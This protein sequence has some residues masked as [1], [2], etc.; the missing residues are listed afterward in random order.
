M[1]SIQYLLRMNMAEQVGYQLNGQV[2]GRVRFLTPSF[3]A[4]VASLVRINVCVPIKRQVG[5]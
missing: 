4:K 5:R 1:K 2:S 3:S